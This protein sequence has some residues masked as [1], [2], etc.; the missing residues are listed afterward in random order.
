MAPKL[1]V[2][3]C[4]AANA[5]GC[6]I[7][8]QR[9]RRIAGIGTS[10]DDVFHDH[11]EVGSFLIDDRG[12]DGRMVKGQNDSRGEQPRLVKQATGE[13]DKFH[14]CGIG[15]LGEHRGRPGSG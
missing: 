14:M 5:A 10:C 8:R 7:D 11:Q 6:L 4:Q 1:A 9:S 2:Q 13:G 12:V 3:F 15:C